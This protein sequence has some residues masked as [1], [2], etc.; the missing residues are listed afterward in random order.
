MTI[1]I[2]ILEIEPNRTMVMMNYFKK[3]WKKCCDVRQEDLCLLSEPFKLD[4]KDATNY[5]NIDKQIA[6]FVELIARSVTTTITKAT[7]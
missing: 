2:H 1:N 6:R 5:S 7:T 4:A 3:V